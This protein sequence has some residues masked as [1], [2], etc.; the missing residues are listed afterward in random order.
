MEQNKPV[1]ESLSPNS[2]STLELL[3]LV[4]DENRATLQPNNTNPLLL[5]VATTPANSY[6]RL[7]HVFSYGGSSFYYLMACIAFLVW[8]LVLSLHIVFDGSNNEDTA[9]VGCERFAHWTQAASA[10]GFG[11]ILVFASWL[12]FAGTYIKKHPQE[13]PTRAHM[14][15]TEPQWATAAVRHSDPIGYSSTDNALKL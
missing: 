5:H 1:L 13:F 4:D 7:V 3:L 11:Y 8:K 6:G 15:V 2:E 9:I 14:I 12:V 10:L